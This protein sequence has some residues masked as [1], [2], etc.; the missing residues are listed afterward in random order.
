[1]L[2]GDSPC[3]RVLTH[4]RD[5]ARGHKGTHEDT[6]TR[7][8]GRW[9]SGLPAPVAGRWLLIAVPFLCSLMKGSGDTELIKTSR[10]GPRA[11]L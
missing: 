6:A 11:R 8:R 9:A 4:H 3:H 2:A 1:M 7:V 5:P 10:G